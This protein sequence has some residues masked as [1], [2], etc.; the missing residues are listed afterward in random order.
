MGVVEVAVAPDL[1]RAAQELAEANGNSEPAISVVYWFPATDEIRLIAVDSTVAST[2]NGDA[3]APFYFKANRQWGAP[4]PLAIA[5]IHP[6]DD[7]HAPLPNGWN[8][9]D[10]AEIIWTRL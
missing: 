6:E 9:W 10:E 8:S 5:L 1:R 7:H 3:I 2:R 4:Y